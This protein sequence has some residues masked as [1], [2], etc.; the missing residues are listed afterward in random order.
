MLDK[1]K[2]IWYNNRAVCRK[3]ANGSYRV[4]KTAGGFEP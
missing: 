2:A 3:S 1:I 4:L